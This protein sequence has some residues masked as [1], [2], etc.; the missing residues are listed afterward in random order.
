MFATIQFRI[1]LSSHLPSKIM[2]IKIY[3]TVILPAVF[4]G[5]ENLSP[6]L[7]EEHRLRKFENEVLRR[8]FRPKK[9]EAKDLG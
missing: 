9:E 2:K 5:H 3:K 6:I 7:R 8:I 4:Y 1:F